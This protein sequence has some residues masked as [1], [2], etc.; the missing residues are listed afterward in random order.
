MLIKNVAATAIIAK[1]AIAHEESHP[2]E[3]KCHR[4]QDIHHG[5]TMIIRNSDEA[6]AYNDILDDGLHVGTWTW[7]TCDSR[8]SRLVFSH[9]NEPA[10]ERDC[11][12]QC[13]IPVE[14]ECGGI[15]ATDNYD[16]LNPVAVLD[17]SNC[18]CQKIKCPRITE[19]D[20]GP[21]HM[22]VDENDKDRDHWPTHGFNQVRVMCKDNMFPQNR[23]TG[24]GRSELLTCDE[25]GWSEPEACLQT[26]CVNPRGNEALNFFAPSMNLEHTWSH[27]DEIDL[28]PH[29]EGNNWVSIND[30]GV[31]Y[32]GD[33]L[34]AV[35][36]PYNFPRDHRAVYT[37]RFTDHFNDIDTWANVL[38]GA[39]AR[40]YCKAGY[41]P[42]YNADIVEAFGNDR[43]RGPQ[44]SDNFECMCNNGK[45]ECQKHCRCEGFCPGN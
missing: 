41:H 20:V 14:H 6:R 3:L 29:D 32:A 45:W 34:H 9:N 17:P 18:H 36:M 2:Q 23:G 25:H 26:A 1:V 30:N 15:N 7:H 37:N 4:P 40:F 5:T 42:Y 8:T 39:V 44:D 11:M 31:H 38:N 28:H 24:H 27:K 12:R 19:E 43:V 22:L 35:S 33:H 10:E 16:I 13:H 21:H